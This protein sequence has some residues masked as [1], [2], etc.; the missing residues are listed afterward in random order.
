M[1]QEEAKEMEQS[2]I[3]AQMSMEKLQQEMERGRNVVMPNYR[4]NDDDDVDGDDL[5]NDT[6]KLDKKKG[7]QL[8][9]K[10]R[11]ENDKDREKGAV[12][13]EVNDFEDVDVI[14]QSALLQR[15]NVAV[16]GIPR[17]DLSTITSSYRR[18]IPHMPLNP[19]IAPVRKGAALRV[20]ETIETVNKSI[21]P[22]NPSNS[23][24]TAWNDS[25]FRDL[26]V[27]HD[28]PVDLLWSNPSS[29]SIIP[30][31][32][33]SLASIMEFNGSNAIR[34]SETDSSSILPSMGWP[35]D[36]RTYHDR[37]DDA[38]KEEQQGQNLI[39]DHGQDLRDMQRDKQRL[40]LKE[41]VDVDD[42]D[43]IMIS[44]YGFSGGIMKGKAAELVRS[45]KAKEKLSN[46]TIQIH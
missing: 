33:T 7:S 46:D 4:L 36:F 17:P 26:Q 29:I 44:D 37:L 9:Y 25:I 12:H 39:A 22:I 15:I 2:R 31:S 27:I 5:N 8:K 19:P 35:N 23:S 1:L 16:S 13:G 41:D 20:I 6:K 32:T 28:H 30:S 14:A 24:M 42:L 3:A 43:V 34:H 21:D 18:N 40:Y 10:K 45:L 38:M 11:N